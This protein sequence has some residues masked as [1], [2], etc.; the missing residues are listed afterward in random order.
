MANEAP[1]RQEPEK[2]VVEK[3]GGMKLPVVIGIVAAALIVNVVLVFAVIKFVL[4]PGQPTGKAQQE[5]VQTKKSE[6]SEE[7]SKENDKLTKFIETG[8]LTTNPK[9]SSEFVVVNLGFV[10][11]ANNEEALKTLGEGKEV[12]LPATS[13][14][15][16]K[17]IVNSVLGSYSSTELLTQRDSLAAIFKNSLK[18]VFKENQTV[19]KEVILQEFILQQ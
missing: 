15:K 19:L 4:A 7:G 9:A 13:M 8:R 10:F 18:P 16:I 17:G 14:A 3:S 12:K 5:T 1:V 11:R 2:P 6:E